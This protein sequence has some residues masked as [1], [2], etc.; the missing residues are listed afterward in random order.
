MIYNSIKSVAEKIKKENI[1]PWIHRDSDKIKGIIISPDTDGFISALFLNEIFGW[2]VIGFY[3][4]KMIVTSTDCDFKNKKESYAFI[5][6]EILRA[7]IKSVGHHIVLYN[8]QNPHPLITSI[9]NNCIQPN[10]WRGMDVKNTFS[11]KYPFGTFHLLI[12]LIY[13]LKP[14]SPAFNFDPKK[15]IVPSIYI[16]GVFKNL[17]NYPENCLD[18]LKYMTGDNPNHP[19]ERLLNHPTTPKDLMNIMKCFFDTLN[20]IWTTQSKRGKGKIKLGKDILSNHLKSDVSKE[21]AEYLSY[22]AQQYNYD[23]KLSLWPTIKDRLTILKLTKKIAPASKYQYDKLL[24]E[25]PIS[26]AVTSKARNGLEYTLDS[27]N[28]LS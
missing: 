7:N 15:A 4:A 27:K 20:N 25:N 10:N 21:L 1:F 18:W 9:E 24:D 11:T 13:Y 12:S 28:I 3:D 5:D 16:D 26:F 14:Q 2:R 17:L 22:L 6:M 19:F 8:V 23:F